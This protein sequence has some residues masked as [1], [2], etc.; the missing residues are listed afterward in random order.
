[1]TP[2]SLR[3]ARITPWP[4]ASPRRPRHERRVDPPASHLVS[5]SGRLSISATISAVQSGGDEGNRTPNPRLAKCAQHYRPSP[6]GAVLCLSVLVECRP[7]MTGTNERQRLCRL[8]AD[9]RTTLQSSASGGQRV[10]R[11]TSWPP[12]DCGRLRRSE[13]ARRGSALRQRRTLQHGTDT[14]QPDGTGSL[15][16]TGTHSGRQGVLPHCLPGPASPA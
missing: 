8:F 3:G 7:T 10:R 9:F 14:G 1:M 12:D 4:V 6:T 15:K 5:R 11:R 13:G 16:V 2:P